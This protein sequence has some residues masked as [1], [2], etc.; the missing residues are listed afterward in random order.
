MLEPVI[1]NLLFQML[2]SRGETT[3]AYWRQQWLGFT[4]EQARDPRPWVVVLRLRGGP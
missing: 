3:R 1:V 2:D 4:P